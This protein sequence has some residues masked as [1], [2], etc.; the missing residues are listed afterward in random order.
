MP[1]EDFIEQPTPE[2]KVKVLIPMYEPLEVVKFG[3]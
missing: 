2:T 1:L 3:R